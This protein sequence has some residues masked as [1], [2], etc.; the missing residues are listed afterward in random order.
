[1]EKYQKDKSDQ[2]LHENMPEK[3]KIFVN[4]NV[5][6]LEW[7][8]KDEGVLRISKIGNFFSSKLFIG[9]L[10]ECIFESFP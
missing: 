1:M 5:G 9:D 6:K 10:I 4:R 8:C 2:G 7:M 3:D